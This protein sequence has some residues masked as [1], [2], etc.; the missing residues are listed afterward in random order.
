MTTPVPTPAPTTPF[1]PT[2]EAGRPVKV[3]LTRRQCCY[4]T[5]YRPAG[6]QRLALGS[7]TVGRIS[8][9]IRPTAPL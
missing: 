5:G 4:G 1:A 8:R 2:R 3:V 9:P 7:S 6:R